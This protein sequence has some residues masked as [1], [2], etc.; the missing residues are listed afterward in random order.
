[1]E[2]LDRERILADEAKKLAGEASQPTTSNTTISA[3]EE[4]AIHA[5][6]R[7]IMQKK[8]AAGRAILGT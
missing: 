2:L 6:V 5:E 7:E 1:M 8:I 3:A 4:A